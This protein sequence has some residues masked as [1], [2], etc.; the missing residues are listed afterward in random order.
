MVC[1]ICGGYVELDDVILEESYN[2]TRK[3]FCETCKKW[4]DEDQ[5]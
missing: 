4:Y 3:F 1:P 5:D 2:T